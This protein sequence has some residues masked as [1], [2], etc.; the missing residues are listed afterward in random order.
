MVK[1]VLET[2]KISVIHY[3]F[4]DKLNLSYK[5]LTYRSHGQKGYEMLDRLVSE[6]KLELE[7]IPKRL[8][9]ADLWV[10]NEEKPKQ[11]AF[12]ESLAYVNRLSDKVFRPK[13]SIICLIYQNVDLLKLVYAQ[14]LKYTDLRDKEF[15]FVANDA[16]PE[17]LQYL[18]QNYIPHHVWEN[19]A[20]QKKEWYINNIYRA[21]NFAAEKAQGDFIVFINSDMA[22][23]LNWLD[24]LIG[25]YNGNNC[26]V[27][28]L[29]E[30]GKLEVGV[31]GLKKNF[32]RTITE[33]KEKEFQCYAQIITNNE[34]TDGGLYM[35]LL[36]RKDKF[37]QIG[38]YPEGNIKA[39][40]PDIF[41]PV[42]AEKKDELIS[43]DK[44]L[45]DKLKS[46]G[47]QHQ[48]SFN[49]IV[50]HFQ[51]GE[52]DEGKNE[53]RLVIGAEIAVCNGLITETTGEK[54]FWNH[55]L[56][57][58]PSS[59]Y[60]DQKLVGGGNFSNKA[61]NYI[62]I[63]HPETK[64]IIQNASFIDFIDKDIFTI[65][66]LQDDLRSTGRQSDQQE[67]NLKLAHKIVTNSYQT[68]AAYRDYPCE[69]ILNGSDSMAKWYNL[70]ENSVLTV[71]IGNNPILKQNNNYSSL[72]FEIEFFYRRKILKKIFGNEDFQIKKYFSSKFIFTLGGS[73]LRKVGL[74][75]VVKKI[76]GLNKK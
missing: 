48:T 37:E 4:S 76:T 34:I 22:F 51:C 12:S 14:V 66:Y 45:I 47:I 71:N 39:D 74:L 57:N 55:L 13:Y 62:Q 60:V 33:F 69:V 59:Y 9:P 75:E 53:K 30:P 29:I 63:N 52:K 40:Y 72:K 36:V 24:N 26:V 7:K 43:G 17:V 41:H 42:I 6:G 3:G 32:G 64:V 23:T 46:I 50:Y 1:N 73:V 27:S 61:K 54:S 8:F 15:Y 2:D 35:P 16:T 11:L 20:A 28:Q 65:A 67:K 68:A 49:S 31:N 44:I 38:G 70:I 5:Y 56:E 58:L 25:S 21:R 10:E 18:R 19:S